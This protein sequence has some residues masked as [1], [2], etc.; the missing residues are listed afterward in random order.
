MILSAFSAKEI[1]LPIAANLVAQLKSL[2]MNISELKAFENN[3][4]FDNWHVAKPVLKFNDKGNGSVAGS[5]LNKVLNNN[6]LFSK[7]VTMS[8]RE[9]RFQFSP[10]WEME[11]KEDKAANENKLN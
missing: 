10:R 7:P 9:Q 2:T 5:I 1:S 11:V 4:T 8:A 3:A 6:L